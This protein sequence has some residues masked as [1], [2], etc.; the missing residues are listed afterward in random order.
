MLTKNKMASEDVTVPKISQIVLQLLC[1]NFQI[2][3]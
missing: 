3:W 1:S 2:I